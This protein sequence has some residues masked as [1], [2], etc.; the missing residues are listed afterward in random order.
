[1]SLSIR[2]D[3]GSVR[4]LRSLTGT[5][6]EQ[7]FERIERLFTRQGLITAGRISKEFLAGQR[8]RRRTANLARSITGRGVRYKGLPAM[9]V[10]VFRGPALDYTAIQ[11]F[12][13][14]VKP[15]KAKALAIPVDGGPAVTPAGVERY[16]G[17]RKFPRPLKFIPSKKPN[18]VGILADTKQ[19]A[20]KRDER[21]R[22]MT[23]RDIVLRRGSQRRDERGRF[24]SGFRIIPVYILMRKVTIKPKHFLRDGVRQRL[25]EIAEAIGEE[26]G[27]MIL[28][29]RDKK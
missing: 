17:P 26:I 2:L 13:G 5:D 8:L 10:G 3:R 11:E 14:V 23:G 29:R 27:K 25:P 15:K 22:F 18:V 24:A 7:A 28:A 19:G 20:Q 1:M 4:F 16:G 9:R 6:K 12:G 21:G